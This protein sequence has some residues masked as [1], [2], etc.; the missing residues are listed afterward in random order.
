MHGRVAHV[1]TS[2]M[3]FVR[4]LRM[5]CCLV[6]SEVAPAFL[7]PS[8]SSVKIEATATSCEYFSEP[9][10]RLKGHVRSSAH[11]SASRILHHIAV[12]TLPAAGRS[13][14]KLPQR[15][16]NGNMIRHTCSG[17]N[18][19]S[20]RSCSVCGQRAP[21]LLIVQTRHFPPSH[22]PNCVP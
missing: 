22:L 16:R 5:F 12:I 4:S 13:S 3:R 11:G 7:K 10:M 15:A 19:A 2:C 6:I 21:R 18:A 17:A 20:E 14:V 9:A 8:F 1:L